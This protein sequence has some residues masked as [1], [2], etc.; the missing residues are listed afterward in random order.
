MFDTIRPAAWL[1]TDRDV[2]VP[3]RYRALRF[4]EHWPVSP[5]PLF[6]AA[7]G[8]SAQRVPTKRMDQALQALAPGL[9]V[10]PRNHGAPDA[11]PYWLLVPEDGEELSD[12]A[13]RTLQ[14]AWLADLCP[15]ATTDPEHRAL[16]R[17]MRGALD[18]D[19]PSWEAVELE[20]LRCPETGGGTAA[21]LHHQPTLATDWIARRITALEPFESE[22]GR[23]EFRPI[24]GGAERGALLVSQPLPLE[25]RNRDSWYSIYLRITMQ[26]QP[27]D[28]LPRFHLHTGVRRWATHTSKTTGRL[29]IPYGTRTTVLLRPKVPWLAGAPLAE[30]FAIAKLQRYR[31]RE[32]GQWTDGWVAGGPA[33]L[34]R[35]ISLSEPFPE[36]DAILTD[37]ELWLT[38]GMRGAVVHRTSMGRHPVLPGLMPDERSEI[39]AW[40]ERALPPELRAMPARKATTLGAPTPRNGRT[41]KPKLDATRSRA[42]AAYAMSCLRNGFP[43]PGPQL[44]EA[45]LLW[46]SEHMR[47]TAVHSLAE[48]LGLGEPK[49][50]P[51]AEEFEKARPGSAA[52][53]E[54]VTP[55]LTVRLRCLKLTDGLAGDLP[56][57]EGEERSKHA[58]RTANAARRDEAAAFLRADEPGPNPSLALVEL[59]RRENFTS[60]H[61]DPKFALRLGFAHAGVLSQFVQVPMKE[62]R[63]DSVKNIE[64]RAENAWNDGLRQLGARL[65]PVP[66][67]RRGT[68][69]AGLSYAALWVVRRDRRS[70]TGWEGIAPLAVRVTPDPSD[71]GLAHIE[72][73]C[74]DAD[75]GAGGWIPYPRALLNLTR[76]TD[77]LAEVDSRSARDEQKRAVQEWLQVVYRSLRN[78]QVLLMAHAQNIRTFWPWMQD[79]VVESDKIRLGHAPARPIHP[80]VRLL[81]VRTGNDS[82]GETAQWWAVAKP[83]QANGLA[84]HLWTSEDGT[85]RVFWSTTAKPGTFKTPKAIRKV[86][87]DA[88]RQAWTPDLVELA[89]LACHPADGDDPETLALVAHHLRQP[90]EY[91]Q[92]LRIPLPLHLARLAEEYILP[93]VDESEE[94]SEPAT[95]E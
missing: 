26:T 89:V 52:V 43:K 4:P 75:D 9:I 47:D 40:A 94:D 22:T 61:H 18:A 84:V 44:L 92:D 77:V 24:P 70:R 66:D 80:G 79:G 56:I 27:F 14:N 95:D 72:G 74:P 21:L 60:T 54:W 28:P 8:E 3:V 53:V 81:R 17:E 12:T 39:M 2:S 1:P 23:L 59:D 62:Q 19:P 58:Q 64:H 36:A 87:P 37:P 31:D 90:P 41:R 30:R 34:L 67:V 78:E 48:Q 6:R 16:L 57:S 32:T 13:F 71:P 82:R 11:A 46:Q 65:L 49:K 38:D 50:R 42:V 88:D 5:L 83:G 73:W 15:S 35:G 86:G 55:E 93:L 29:R 20:L 68:L 10:L 63:H 69:P 76:R 91:D 7:R 85:D 25:K 45:R 51:T 33:G